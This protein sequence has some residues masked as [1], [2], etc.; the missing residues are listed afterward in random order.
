MLGDRH[1]GGVEQ[2]ST[3]SSLSM[4]L[5][6]NAPTSSRSVEPSSIP[7]PSHL[8]Q[9]N[10]KVCPVTSFRT[11]TC[12]TIHLGEGPVLSW[13]MRKVDK[14]PRFLC[15]NNRIENR[16]FYPSTTSFLLMSFNENVFDTLTWKT[17][18]NAPFGMFTGLVSHSDP[19]IATQPFAEVVAALAFLLGNI[20]TR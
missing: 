12:S 15:W 2:V 3:S 18:S 8:P 9:G 1:L 7:L 5:G 4:L 17:N 13:P 10:L 19:E 16:K 20:I 11:T 6:T 14:T